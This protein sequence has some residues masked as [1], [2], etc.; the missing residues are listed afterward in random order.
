MK[1]VLAFSSGHDILKYFS[2]SCIVILPKVNNPNKLKE[3]KPICLSNFISKIISKLFSTRL[4]R[5]LPRFI[6]L[7]KSGFV[8]GRNIT[9]NIMLAQEITHQIKKPYI[10]SNLIIMVDKAKTYDRVSWAYIFLVLRKMGFE[11]TFIDMVWR[12]MAYNWY[13]I[14]IN[15]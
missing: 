4:S 2:Y 10:G 1:V 5:I 9:E 3:F 14:I 15:G 13:S 7:N 6:S 11:E 8:K 12:T